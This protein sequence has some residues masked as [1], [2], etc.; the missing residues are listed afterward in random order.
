M[1]SRQPPKVAVLM[2]GL[3]AEREVSLSSGRM[4]A[5]ALREAGFQVVEV[6]ARRDLARRIA[7]ARS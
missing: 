4:C 6:D 5:A 2:G 7:Q 1:S 3:S